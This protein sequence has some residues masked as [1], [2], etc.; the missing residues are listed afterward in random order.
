S[1]GLLEGSDAEGASVEI[2]GGGVTAAGGGGATGC[3]ASAA[4]D[5]CSAGSGSAERDDTRKRN[6]ATPNRSAPAARPATIRTRRCCVSGTAV[7]SSAPSDISTMPPSVLLTG[8]RPSKLP[9]FPV[10]VCASGIWWPIDDGSDGST[11]TW[12]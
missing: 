4:T 1:A 12:E 7:A 6:P 10:G 9:V 2:G 5:A 11:V 3:G 8:L